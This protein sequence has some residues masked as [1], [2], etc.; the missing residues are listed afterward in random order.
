MSASSALD[1][2]SSQPNRPSTYRISHMAEND[3][4][5]APNGSAMRSRFHRSDRRA[6]SAIP[7]PVSVKITAMLSRCVC[8]IVN[9]SEKDLENCRAA[10]GGAA[11]GSTPR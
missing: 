6:H 5:S 11:S 9:I 1:A 8:V 3:T 10:P 4:S 2:S 7:T